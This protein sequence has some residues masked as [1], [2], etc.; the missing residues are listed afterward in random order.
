MIS[1]IATHA[2]MTW[3]HINMLGEYDFSEEKLKDS[4]GILPLKINA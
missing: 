4:V 3:A 1:M 2:P